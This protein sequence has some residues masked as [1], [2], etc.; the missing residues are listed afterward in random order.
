MISLLKSLGVWFDGEDA[1]YRRAVFSRILAAGLGG[2]AVTALA[3]AALSVLL[4]KL[5]EATPAHAILAATLASFSLYTAIVILAFSIRSMARI[6]ALLGL[7][8][9]GC[10]ALLFAAYLI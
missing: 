2:Y 7:S 8:C 4:P 6:S 5:S 1:R 10:G 9:L 3:T